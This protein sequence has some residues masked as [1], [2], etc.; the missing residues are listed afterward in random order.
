MTTDYEEREREK[1]KKKTGLTNP[2]HRALD[3]RLKGKKGVS[4]AG[5]GGGGSR[6]GRIP[7]KPPGR[8]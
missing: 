2:I 1:Q 7:L 3:R 5:T 4:D 8:N 6:L